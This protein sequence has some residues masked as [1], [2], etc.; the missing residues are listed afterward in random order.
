MRPVQTDPIN[1]GDS[2]ADGVLRSR[3]ASVGRWVLEHRVP[4]GRSRAYL[5]LAATVVFAAGVWISIRSRSVDLTQLNIMALVVLAIVGVP[6]TALANAVEYR[7]SAQVVGLTSSMGS[8]FRVSVYSTAANLLPLPGS[9]MVRVGALRMS[10]V[11][12]KAALGTTVYVGLIWLGV[13]ATLAGLMSLSS[14]IPASLLLGVGVCGLGV[15]IV[16]LRRT[17]EGRSRQ[18]RMLLGTVGVETAKIS[19]GALRAVLALRSLGIAAHAS[20]GIV[21]ALSSA[22]ASS[23]GVFPGGLGLREF[24]AAG[25]GPLVSVAPGAAYLAVAVDRIAGMSIHGLIAL[26]LWTHRRQQ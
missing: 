3:L 19:I 26:L 6:L 8:S 9:V 24:A 25:L 10:G 20:Q 17:V 7:L 11:R 22:V 4:E 5:L 21:L 23:V 15:G 18:W 14:L 12:T 2:G 16:Y 1:P 13:S